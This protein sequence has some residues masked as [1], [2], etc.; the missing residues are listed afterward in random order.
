MARRTFLSCTVQHYLVKLMRRV[1]PERIT[2]FIDDDPI[3]FILPAGWT[4]TAASP[5]RFI[6]NQ[7]VPA[8]TNLWQMRGTSQGVS[9][10]IASH[11]GA[12]IDIIMT[13]R[14]LD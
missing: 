1:N 13:I 9:Q 12:G 3:R 2:L 10:L 6:V 5:A 11:A 7:V 14:V 8:T 4:L